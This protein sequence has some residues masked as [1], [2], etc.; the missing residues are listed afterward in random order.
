[1]G[2]MRERERELVL[3]Q[4]LPSY[5]IHLIVICFFD[6]LGRGNRDIQSSVHLFWS[7]IREYKAFRVMVNTNQSMYKGTK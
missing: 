4:K 2:E 3:H 7:D 1:M 6:T 5:T